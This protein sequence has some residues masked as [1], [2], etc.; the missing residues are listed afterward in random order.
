MKKSFNSPSVFDWMDKIQSVE[1]KQAAVPVLDVPASKKLCAHCYEEISSAPIN[2]DMYEKG[3]AP[4]ICLSQFSQKSKSFVPLCDLVL[5]DF[6][7]YEDFI[8]YIYAVYSNRNIIVS[9]SHFCSDDLA[10]EVL[11]SEAAFNMIM[12]RYRYNE[13]YG[14]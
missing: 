6:A 8:S 14:A 3:F 10:C 11:Y 7:D 9:G 5:T 13:R 12:E 2:L 1:E 4:T